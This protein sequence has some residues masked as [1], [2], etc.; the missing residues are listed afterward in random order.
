MEA[1]RECRNFLGFAGGMVPVG[2][3]NELAQARVPSRHETLG[4]LRSSKYEY[5]LGSFSAV[6]PP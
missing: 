1:N 5:A 4:P 3:K 6:L 2:S